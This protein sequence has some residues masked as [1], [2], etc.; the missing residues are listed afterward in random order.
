MYYIIEFYGQNQ[1]HPDFCYSEFVHLYFNSVQI[2]EDEGF[3]SFNYKVVN[4]CQEFLRNY[5]D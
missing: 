5:S 3:Q 4:C 1:Y 2:L